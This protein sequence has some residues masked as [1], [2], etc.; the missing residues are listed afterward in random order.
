MNIRSCLI[1]CHAIYHIS[2][3]HVLDFTIVRSEQF[4]YGIDNR[5]SSTFFLPVLNIWHLQKEERKP[6]KNNWQPMFPRSGHHILITS[7]TKKRKKNGTRDNLC[8][9]IYMFRL[10]LKIRK[11]WQPTLARGLVKK[12]SSLCTHYTHTHTHTPTHTHLHTHTHTHLHTPTYFR[13]HTGVYRYNNELCVCVCVCVCVCAAVHAAASS[14]W[15]R[16]SEISVVI[17]ITRSEAS[18]IKVH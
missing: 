18:E 5:A 15:K 2:H 12:Q 9:T 7:F 14:D 11:G 13:P 6:V 3:R 17:Y 16:L 4:V 1:I 8:R 10:L